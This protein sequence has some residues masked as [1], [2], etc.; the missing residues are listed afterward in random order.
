MFRLD[1]RN[2]SVM[3]AIKGNSREKM[4]V[5][6]L[7]RVNESENLGKARKFKVK[8]FHCNLPGVK[9]AYLNFS[10]DSSGIFRSKSSR[11]RR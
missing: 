7:S 1:L 4:L 9:I 11:M 10:F 2:R 3:E 8:S 5:T 6:Y